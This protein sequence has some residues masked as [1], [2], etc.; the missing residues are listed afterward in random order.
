VP[1]DA[2]PG[3][4]D[5]ERIDVL[6]E[7]ARGGTL[8]IDNIGAL[9]NELWA[10]L[11]L[12][13]DR[14]SGIRLIAAGLSDALLDPEALLE[15]LKPLVL[16]MPSL[17]ERRADIPALVH[18]FTLQ[19]NLQAAT[20]RYLKQNEVDDLIASEF[21]RDLRS[22]KSASFLRLIS[23][24]ETDITA[25]DAEVDIHG[26]TLDECTT[27]FEA[28]L[29]ADTLKRCGGNKS[30]AARLLGLRPNTLHYKLER[31]G[32]LERKKNNN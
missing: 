26:K 3:A 30:K 19:F 13:S 27:E 25:T 6:I 9:S 32:L 20:E 10:R 4:A 11:L 31:Y 8:M 5:I 7:E 23:R 24:D 28:R 1:G 21:P 15:P 17:R 2:R 12:R 22:L 16:E 29:I 14:L 18:Y